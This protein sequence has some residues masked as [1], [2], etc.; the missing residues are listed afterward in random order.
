MTEL[1]WENGITSIRIDDLSDSG[2]LL[3]EIGSC[4]LQQ[5]NLPHISREHVTLHKSQ[6]RRYR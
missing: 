4:V 5:C 6:R 2:T 1:S 3:K